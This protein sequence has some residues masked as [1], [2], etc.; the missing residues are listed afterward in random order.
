MEVILVLIAV[1]IGWFLVRWLLSAGARTVGAAVKAAVGKGSFSE[2]MDLA[3]KGM[4]PLE[5]QFND[6]RLGEDGSGAFVKEIVGRGLFP[7]TQLVRVGCVTSVLDATSED[8]EPI[9]SVIEGFQELDN[10]VYQ[11]RFDVGEVAPDQ[12]F[13]R[14]VRLGVVIPEILQPPYG[15][16]RN[17]IAILRLIDLDNPPDINHGFNAPDQDGLLWQDS[18]Q[19]SYT[20][21]EKGYKEAA[22]HRDESC[23]LAIQ[24]AMAVAMADGS[25][26]DLEG[27]TLKEWIVRTIEPFGDEKR[28]KLK[29]LYNEA[30]REAYTKAQSGD[31]NL[32]ELTERL[33]E[34]GE[35]STKYEVVELCFDIMA[36]D[37]VADAEELRV[38]RR[39]ADAL[40]LDLDEIENM[41]DQRIIGLDT[42]VSNQASIEDILGIEPN[43]DEKRIK[44]YLRT[45]FQKWNNRIN[46]LS[47]GEEREN[48][49]R[50]LDLISEAR[51]QYG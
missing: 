43:W 46:T 41:R 14:W 13:I 31:L 25:L 33:N 21:D 19:F 35:K 12:G 44:K 40:D 10:V 34:I 42:S 1:A 32:G 16:K 5:I 23:A 26:D 49:Q 30:M 47:E 29:N 24:I 11:H 20:F 51:R 48:A 45:E 37:G 36:A 6:S 4:G 17:L 28:N 3:F 22:E 9:I 8:Y 39:V 15:G 18:L 38:I 2:N 27:N 7:V 50:M